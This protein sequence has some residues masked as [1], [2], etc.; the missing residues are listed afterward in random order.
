[1]CLREQRPARVSP[2]QGDL[3]LWLLVSLPEVLRGEAGCCNGNLSQLELPQADGRDPVGG[4]AMEQPRDPLLPT[5]PLFSVHLQLA[6][7]VLKGSPCCSSPAITCCWAG[8]RRCD[9]RFRIS[10]N[11][12]LGSKVF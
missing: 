1:M 6:V 4:Q 9:F 2:G 8:A 3:G 5:Q 11:R 12:C 10:A 7:A